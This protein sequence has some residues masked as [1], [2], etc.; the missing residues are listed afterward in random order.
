[1]YCYS[2]VVQK[3]KNLGV[4]DCID[5]DRMYKRK[6]G[7]L[8]QVICRKSKSILFSFISLD[9]IRYKIIHP[10]DLLSCLSN[11]QGLQKAMIYTKAW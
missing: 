1:M 8:W 9:S 10:S 4:F 3:K 2:G 5:A 11:C 7:E 6:G